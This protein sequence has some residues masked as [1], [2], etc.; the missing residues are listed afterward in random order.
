M[1]SR[2]TLASELVENLKSLLPRIVTVYPIALLL[3]AA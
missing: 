2:V 3:A 1:G